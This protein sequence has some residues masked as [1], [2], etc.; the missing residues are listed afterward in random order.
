MNLY[1]MRHG[2]A[3]PYGSPGIASDEERPLSPKG[4]KRMRKAAR[5]L[6]ALDINLDGVFTSPLPRARQTAEIVAEVLEVK[7]QP[8]ELPELAPGGSVERLLSGLSALRDKKRL[9]LVGHQPLLG[10][11]ASF[12]LAKD[13]GIEISLKKGG[14]WCIELEEPRFDAPAILRWALTPRQL[15]L[16]AR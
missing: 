10:E 5:G 16:L 12:L 6:L 2:I 9:L 13:K 1:L 8:Q 4:I 3:V 14:L 7:E 11:T 15:R